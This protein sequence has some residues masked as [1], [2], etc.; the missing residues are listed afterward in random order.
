MST[1]LTNYKK[2]KEYLVIGDFD[3]VNRFLRGQKDVEIIFEKIRPLGS[4]LLDI[5]T[6]PEYFADVK[7]NFCETSKEKF[8]E[9]LKVVKGLYEAEKVNRYSRLP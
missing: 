3:N 1:N 7:A 4:F 2:K 8:A 6:E 5:I 9:N